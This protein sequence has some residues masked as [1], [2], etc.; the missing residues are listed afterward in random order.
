MTHGIVKSARRTAGLALM[1]A[2]AIAP[3]ALAQTGPTLTLTFT[4]LAPLDEA[5]EGLYEG[6]AI[7]DGMPVST[8]VFNVDG[9]GNPVMP[10]GGDVIEAFTPAEDITGATEIKI[11]IEPADDGDPAPSGL[12]ILGGPLSGDTASLAT[13]LET[14]SAAGGC[15]IIATPSDNAVDDMN[16]DYG[17]WWLTMPGPMAGLTDLPALGAGWTYEGWIVDMSGGMPM[18]YSTGTFA[19]GDMADS[20]MAGAMGGGPPF[21]GQDFVEYHGGPVL[22]LNSGDF[23]AVISIEPVPD[24]SPAP[25]QLKPLAGMIAQGASAGCVDNQ[26]SATFPTG[27]A[28]LNATVPVEGESLS[29]VKDLFR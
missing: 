23:A 26:T 5:A 6:W 11:S 18:P 25:F 29:G 4:N 13:G 1:V 12:I 10:G 8:G 21:P 15:Y 17:I 14:V 2:L 27:L 9:A 3:A 7:V 19:S 28:L 24:N 16:D 22:M 20:D